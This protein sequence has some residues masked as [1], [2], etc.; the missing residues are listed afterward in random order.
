MDGFFSV[1]STRWEGFERVVSK[2]DQPARMVIF[3]MPEDGECLS[4]TF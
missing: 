1:C 4:L 3:M 2:T